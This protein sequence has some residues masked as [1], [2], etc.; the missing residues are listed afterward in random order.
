MVLTRKSRA[1]TGEK[2]I[3]V[4]KIGKRWLTN[5]LRDRRWIFSRRW[6]SRISRSECRSKE[7]QIGQQI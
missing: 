2:E 4:L 7:I 3:G 1:L 6:E 5:G